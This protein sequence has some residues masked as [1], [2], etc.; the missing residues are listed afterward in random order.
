MGLSHFIDGHLIFNKVNLSFVQEANYTKYFLDITDKIYNALN[1]GSNN[2]KEEDVGAIYTQETN[3]AFDTAKIIG[4]AGLGWWA[5]Q[6]ILNKRGWIN[7]E[8]DLLK[9]Y[10][11][12][13]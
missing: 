12:V 2:L 6:T 4:A 13:L 7:F 1:V 9:G 8:K 11:G 10:D 3:V 5:I